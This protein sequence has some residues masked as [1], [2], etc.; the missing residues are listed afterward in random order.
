MGL[1]KSLLK[2]K[3]AEQGVERLGK[4]VAEKVA[5]EVG[6]QGAKT[7]SKAANEVVAKRP[8]ELKRNLVNTSSIEDQIKRITKNQKSLQTRMTN[9]QNTIN[10]LNKEI[11]ASRGQIQNMLEHTSK[12]NFKK[13][14]AKADKIRATIESKEKEIARITKNLEKNQAKID[15]YAEQIQSLNNKRLGKKY[16]LAPE[17]KENIASDFYNKHQEGIKTAVGLGVGGALMYSVFGN[18]G[19]Q[20]NAQLY[21]QNQQY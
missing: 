14:D 18:K 2:Y 19:Q 15:S 9:N 21:G 1:L 16:V 5:E 12:K 17:A 11:E 7:V 3:G 4:N 20:S 10:T 13:V 8:R 6:E